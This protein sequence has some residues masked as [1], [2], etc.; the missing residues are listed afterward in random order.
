VNLSIDEYAHRDSPLHRWDPRL[1]FLSLLALIF[2]FSVVND[3]R[4][5]PVI[6]VCAVVT[7][8]LSGIPITY[9][10]TRLRYPGYFLLA[11]VVLLPV[12][13]G[14]TIIARLGPIALRKEGLLGTLPIAA[15][16]MAI[17]TVTLTL[18]GTTPFLTTVKV[19]RSFG[20]PALLTDV[21]LLAYRYLFELALDLEK[22]NRAMRLRGWQTLKL[23]PNT[24]KT[25]SS[26]IGA[27]L[28][29]SY[30]RSERVYRAMILRGYGHGGQVSYRFLHGPTDIAASCGTFLFAL[31]LVTSQ[32]LLQ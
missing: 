30:E 12:I 23:N 7:F 11:L 2:A 25:L 10:V 8:S 4:L 26:V 9:L 28:V 3:L 18:F 17:L 6:L 13:S 29:R 1:K 22:I 31:G 15:R 19:L 24:A 20:L 21:L 5:L 27:L 14:S 16:F 32:V